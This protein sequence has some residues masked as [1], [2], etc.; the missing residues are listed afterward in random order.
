MPEA[1]N[2]YGRMKDI[3]GVTY[4]DATFEDFQRYFK[5]T[6]IQSEKCNDKGLEFPNKCSVP[7]CNRCIYNQGVRFLLPY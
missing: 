7:P 5:C 3:C 4:E 6:H 1:P 2:W